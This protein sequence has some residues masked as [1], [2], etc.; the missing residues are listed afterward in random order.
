MES[1]SLFV[2][3]HRVVCRLVEGFTT[4]HATTRFSFA[5]LSPRERAV[6]ITPAFTPLSPSPQ[7]SW[8]MVGKKK[9]VSGQKESGQTDAGEEGKENRDRGGDRDAA[10]A[11]RRGGAP[12]R[13]RAGSRGRECECPSPCPAP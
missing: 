6:K 12:R 9:G 8:E 2:W 4:Q 10:A 5:G 3:K 7:D 11:R 13:G 1:S